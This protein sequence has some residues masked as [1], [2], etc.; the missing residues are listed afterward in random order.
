MKNENWKLF[1]PVTI[2][3]LQ[4]RNRIALLPMGNKLQSATGEV[5]P[6][7]IDFYEEVAKGGAGLVIV[8]AAYVT[9]EFGGK[10]L[11]IYSDD[12]VSGLNCLAETIKAWGARVGIQISH[13]GYRA[14]DKKSVNTMNDQAIENMIEAFGRAAE[15]ARRAGFEMVEIH[16]AHGYLIPQFLSGLTNERTDA[17]GGGWE[18]RMTFPIRVYRKVR[19]AVGEDF[20]ISFRLSGDEFVR[21]GISLEDTKKI[22][23]IL[24][25]EGVDLISLSAGKG[26]ETGEWSIQPMALPRGCLAHLSQELKPLIHIPVLVAGRINDPVLAN[27]ILEEGKADLVGMGRALIADP[28]LPRKAWEGRLP[29]IRK[30]LACNY[31]HGKRLI[32]ELPLKCTVN[33]EAGRRREM[34]LIPA[35]KKKRVLVAGGG[36][37]GMECAYTLHQ[38]GHEVLLFE[39]TAFLGGKLRLAAIPPHKEE[40]REFTEFLIQRIWREKIPVFLNYEVEASTLRAVQPDA[41]VLATG[42]KAICPSIPG[43]DK[44]FCITVEEALT[45][46]LGARRILV[47][48]GGMV[49]CETAEFLAMKGKKITLVEKLPELGLDVEPRTRKLLLKRLLEFRPAIHTSTEVVRVEGGRA[50]LRDLKGQESEASFAAFVFAAGFAADDSLLDSLKSAALEIQCIGD[51]SAPRGILEAIHEGNRA[52]RLI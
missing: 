51:C 4:V 43:M 25:G 3:G 2:K 49:G 36:P 42:A 16:G 34:A 8:Q 18:K 45:R 31:C 6:Q 20:P 24:E 52:G 17:Y 30:C 5:T 40:I 39:K 33:P 14:A 19:E 10:R 9:D 21:G 22:A 7:L 26:P 28:W 50:I 23:R 27:S 47:L 48:G 37:G 46:D 44:E 35:R 41:L 12:Y 13:P 15:R 1:T 38:R 32:F 11:V 29:E